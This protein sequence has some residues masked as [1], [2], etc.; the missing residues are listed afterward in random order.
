[1]KNLL[2]IALLALVASAGAQD[3]SK[4][5][6]FNNTYGYYNATVVDTLSS[7]QDTVDIEFAL[8]A[9]SGSLW[10]LNVNLDS[11]IGL[12]EDD[13]VS[14][15]PY[16][17]MFNTDTWSSIGSIDYWDTPADNPITFEETSTRD[18]INRVRVRFIYIG[19][20]GKATLNNANTTDS[21]RDIELK[22]WKP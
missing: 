17:R 20:T 12:G 1:M 9:E 21:G 15:E 19:T 22:I 6:R 18:F 14:I 7:N 10:D 8:S 16:G 4:Y 2:I 3:L 13:S 11:I 5:G